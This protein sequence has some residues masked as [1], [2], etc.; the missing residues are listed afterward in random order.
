MKKMFQK[1]F[2]NFEKI[3][4][5][6]KKTNDYVEFYI[7]THR[8]I[9]RNTGFC[10]FVK[11]ALG[12]KTNFQ[13][14]K[15]VTENNKSIILNIKQE[16][17]SFQKENEKNLTQIQK[18]YL[19]CLID[20]INAINLTTDELAKIAEFLYN[21]NINVKNIKHYDFDKIK[22]EYSDSVRNYRT[23]QKLMFYMYGDLHADLL[24]KKPIS[25]ED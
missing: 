18:S 12:F 15:Q 19:N 14:L 17:M 22:N 25:C 24:S 10:R 11:N 8:K 7:Q 13:E 20:Y 16:T 1:I 21:L 5:L 9:M 2:S 3:E 4:T 23:Q 6:T